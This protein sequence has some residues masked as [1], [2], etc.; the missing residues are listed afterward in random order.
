MAIPVCKIWRLHPSIP[1]KTLFATEPKNI[2]QVLEWLREPV[3]KL[4]DEIAASGGN[5]VTNGPAYEHLMRLRKE[6]YEQILLGPMSPGEVGEFL[7]P[8]LEN[9]PASLKLTVDATLDQAQRDDQR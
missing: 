6:L 4:D 1:S 5:P 2:L 7:A 9:V 8:H 3:A